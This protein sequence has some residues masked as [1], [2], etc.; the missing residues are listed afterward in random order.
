MF[1]KLL[2]PLSC[3]LFQAS[4]STALRLPRTRGTASLSTRLTLRPTTSRWDARVQ[5]ASGLGDSCSCERL[6]TGPAV[7]KETPACCTF[8]P[9]SSPAAFSLAWPHI[10]LLQK[11]G[12]QYSAA[13]LTDDDKAEIRALARDPRIGQSYPAVAKLLREVQATTCIS[14]CCV[15]ALPPST[16]VLRLAAASSGSHPAGAVTPSRRR[17]HRQVNCALYLRPPEHQAGHRSGAVWR[18]R[19]SSACLHVCWLGKLLSA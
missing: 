17:A 18:V 7:L 16:A 19:G 6:W 4:T 10:A 14:Y 1:L 12:D 2:S 13:R 11:K 3:L 15:F 5:T 9:A 8:L